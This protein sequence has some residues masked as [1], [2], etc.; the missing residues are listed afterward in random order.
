MIVLKEGILVIN[1]GSDYQ[2]TREKST[3]MVYREIRDRYPDM[4]LYECFT[5]R[6]ILNLS[7]E[8]RKA[9]NYPN[10][11]ETLEKIAGDGIEHLYV[12]MTLLVPVP[13]YYKALETMRKYKD[14]IP[15]IQVT[16]PAIYDRSDS[17]RVAKALIDA[18]KFDPEKAYILLAHGTAELVDDCYVDVT[19]EI[20]AAGYKLVYVA[21]LKGSPTLSSA[22]GKLQEYRYDDIVTIVPFMVGAG[23]SVRSTLDANQNPFL[24]KISKAGFRTRSVFKGVAE[25]HEFREVLYEKLAGIMADDTLGRI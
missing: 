1:Y 10:L 18:V 24:S 12:S 7:D 20:H 3:D 23:Y 4:P 13:E 8:E 19:R 17:A 5:N 15:F 21:L 25:Y 22:I 2:E 16:H 9:R 6:R 14:R 11:E